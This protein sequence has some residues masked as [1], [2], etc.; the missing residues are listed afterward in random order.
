MDITAYC[1]FPEF[2]RRGDGYVVIDAA[3]TATHDYTVVIGHVTVIRGFAHF[4]G[5][6]F[7]ALKGLK[8]VLSSSYPLEDGGT[9][10][11][12]VIGALRYALKHGLKHG[13]DD[14]S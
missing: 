3:A 4:T 8:A 2:Q 13:R 10:T 9:M 5:D 11:G 7:S 6:R 14:R 1:E 12:D